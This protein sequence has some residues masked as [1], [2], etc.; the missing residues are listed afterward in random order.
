MREEK[1]QKKKP[2]KKKT[3]Q[4]NKAQHQISGSFFFKIN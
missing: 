1:D 3:L 2:K 4:D